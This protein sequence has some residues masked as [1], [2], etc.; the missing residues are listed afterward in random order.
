LIVE[1]D[2]EPRSLMAALFKDEQMDTVECES[3]QA[4]LATLL[5]G[6]REVA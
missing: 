3:A 4:A 6:G 2:A 5:I 1:D